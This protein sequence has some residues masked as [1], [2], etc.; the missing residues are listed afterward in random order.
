VSSDG[1]SINT[2]V[3]ETTVWSYNKTEI[4]AMITGLNAM[5]TGSEYIQAP[6]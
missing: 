3:I 6:R 1:I 2:P 5:I 4:D